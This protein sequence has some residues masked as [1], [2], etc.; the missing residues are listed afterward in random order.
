MDA[1]QVKQRLKVRHCKYCG[2]DGSDGTR[3]RVNE[4]GVGDVLDMPRDED[5]DADRIKANCL[6][7][8]FEDG[9]LY[10]LIC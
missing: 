1:C 9:C 6:R 7:P 5:E 10:F 3:E 2:T 4:K 8:I